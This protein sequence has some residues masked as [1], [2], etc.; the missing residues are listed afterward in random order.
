MILYPHQETG[1][2]WLLSHPRAGLFDDQGLGKTAQVIVAAD[3]LQVDHGV[4]QP[5]HRMLVIAPSVVV[6]NWASEMH[7]WS[8]QRR[9][10][11]VTTGRTEIDSKATAVIVPHALLLKPAIVSQLRGFEVTVLDEAHFL[12]NPNAKRTRA[13]FLGADAVCRRSP[14]CWALTGTPM[15][16]NPT[17]LWPMLAGLSPG[18]L[19]DE[20]TGKLMTYARFRDR[21]CVTVPSGYGN[22][23]K[24][25]G[26]Q[27]APDLRKRLQGFSLRR[28][29]TDVLKSLPPIRFGTV[30]VD[31]DDA[32]GLDE[33]KY[34]G[35]SGEALLE[36]LKRG[37]AFSTW[38][39]LC[40]LAKVPAAAELLRN[41]LE[42]GM[43]KVV[44]FAH[45]IEVIARLS[46]LLAEFG[47]VSI[48]G[49]TPPRVR[50]VA[51][52][53]FQNDPTIRVCLAQIVAGGVGVTLTAASDVV[54][55]E[56]S[57]VPGE[58][59]QAAD[60]C[61]RIGQTEPV[62]ARFLALVGSVDE[63]LVDILLRK[64]EM[65]RQVL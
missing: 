19:R 53:M 23:L 11:V 39:R 49:T 37:E 41:D 14:H 30:V 13:F 59:A 58:N 57:F 64:T 47:V 61:H 55:V 50:S 48:T 8:P 52:T 25:I 12:R 18:R 20:A 21:F 36:E 34:R 7:R 44:V 38:R 1:V 24:V 9:V 27:N 33:Q 40:G 51:V 60:R 62:L 28:M 63:V 31:A 43:R 65:Q 2:Q 26:V 29:K 54:F 6:Y 16:N 10:Q 56:Q 45:H 22:G 35:L 15:P 46:E 17:E 5:R 42:G 32:A 3:R 4:A